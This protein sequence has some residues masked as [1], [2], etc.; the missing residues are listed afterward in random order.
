[1][2]QI[3]RPRQNGNECR[4][5]SNGIVSVAVV[6]RV[7]LLAKARAVGLVAWGLPWLPH[8]GTLWFVFWLLAG[9]WSG[10]CNRAVR[11]GSH[12]FAGRG[13]R[14]GEFCWTGYKGRFD[15]L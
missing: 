11:F 8:R 14:W 7:L 15:A 3:S 4:R 2:R 13:F 6:S 12:V 5:I 10:E 1:M 9:Y